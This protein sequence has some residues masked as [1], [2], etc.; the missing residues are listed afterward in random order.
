MAATRPFP[1]QI[2][3]P[4]KLPADI[5]PVLHV[6]DTPGKH[7]TTA[8]IPR[9]GATRVRIPNGLKGAAMRF[10]TSPTAEKQ[11][12]LKQLRRI[13]AVE[14]IRPFNPDDELIIDIGE[15]V[16]AGWI[17]CICTVRGKVVKAVPQ[18]TG[19]SVDYPVCNARVH[20]CEVDKIPRIIWTIPDDIILRVRDELLVEPFPPDPIGPVIRRFPRDLPEPPEPPELPGPPGPP[21]AGGPIGRSLASV[22]SSVR[23]FLT[24]AE[25]IKESTVVFTNLRRAPN[26][27]EVRKALVNLAVL[28]PWWC[29]YPWLDPYFTYEV[30]CL[31][32]VWTDSSGSFEKT[33]VHSCADTPDIYIWVEQFIAGAW[34]TIYARGPRCDTHWNYACGSEI[35]I[36]VTDPDAIVCVPPPEV[37]VPSGITTW[38]LP[39]AVGA[40]E[41]AGTSSHASDP[42]GWVQADGTASYAGPSSAP[43][44]APVMDAPLGGYLRFKMLHSLDLPKAGMTRYVWSYRLKPSPNP[45]VPGGWIKMDET[46]VRKYQVPGSGGFPIFPVHTLGPDADGLFHFRP[47]SPPAGVWPVTGFTEDL[48]SAK[49]NTVPV[50]PGLYQVRVTVHNAAGAVVPPSPGTFQFVATDTRDAWKETYDT[51]AASAAELIDDGFVFDLRIDNAHCTA[52]LHPTQTSVGAVA[53]ACGFLRYADKSLT[54]VTLSF[55]ASHPRDQAWF[56]LDLVRGFT[57]LNQVEV[58]DG[59]LV[60]AL[61]VP[62]DS[63][64]GITWANAFYTGDGAG[65]FSGTFSALRFLEACDNAA[66][67]ADLYTRVKAHNG[68]RRLHEYDRHSLMAFALA[69]EPAG[70]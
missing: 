56:T 54:D 46:V 32:E 23:A 61:S 19:V 1:V 50:A 22:K 16:V 31:W 44:V 45:T 8:K 65:N 13:S 6:G 67:A 20:I 62:V 48:W 66:F 55:E 64:G 41:I 68:L 30:D 53:D 58:G 7:I 11:P 40:M 69:E 12:T 60:G 42:L 57:D 33:F 5:T 15:G 63:N 34:N 35:T 17:L 28:Y 9:N 10:V 4:D 43:N 2:N 14:T 47:H 36:R 26:T 21:G 52:Q 49:F 51:R 3:L 25:S 24:T 18:P 39:M 70:P 29:W 27:V 37:V 59:G 38:V